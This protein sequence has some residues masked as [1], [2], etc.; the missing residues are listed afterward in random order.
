[1]DKDQTRWLDATDQATLVRRREVEPLELV[2]AAIERIEELDPAIGAV[3]IRWFD[4]ALEQAAQATTDVRPEDAPFPG[5]P[6]LLKDLHLHER[7]Q[8]LTNGNVAL[9]HEQPVSTFDAELVTRMRRTGLVTLGR[10][11]SSE[12]GT[13]PVTE[14]AAY[15]PTRNPWN[16]D[17]TPG[18]S[19]GG[20]AAA[21]AAGMVP[22]AHASDGGGSIRIPA[23]CCGLVGLKPTNGRISLAPDRTET[24]LAVDFFVTRSVRD[25]AQLLD[26]VSGS[27]V[28]DALV[29]APPSRPFA[30]E[31]GAEPG[32]LR[33][34]LLDQHPL[35][36]A[37]HPDCVEAVQT[38]ARRLEDLGH[39][40]EPSWPT[41][42]A[43]R[44]FDE[45][46]FVL[47]AVSR[48][49]GIEQCSTMLGRPLEAAEVEAHDWALGEFGRAVSGVDHANALA[50]AA[51]MRRAILAWW[52]EG[53]D[54]LL[55]PTLAAPPL[56]IGA[57]DPPPNNPLQA[58]VDA[59]DFVGF[60]GAFNVT[61]QPAISIPATWNGDGLPIGVQLVADRSAE[62]LLLRVAS[63]LE[64]AHP[65]SHRTPPR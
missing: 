11:T 4:A 58:L 17:R 54:L 50:S 55:T 8:V 31:V 39:H 18:G 15:G 24:G 49:M 10:S 27:G 1:M 63:Q 28:G 2:E 35:G 51:A 34:G 22:V 36:R 6:T 12:L 65:W 53:F 40:V 7:G 5:V 29:M 21:V 33:I 26:A 20:A 3:A 60:T 38:V 52:A 56:P 46:F 23:S 32:R 16:L 64:S 41:A 43:D 47:W 57:L 9:Q 19:S 37:L 45:M 25:A 62:E 14:T 13:L 59:N 44:S 61:G 48:A 42:L 30:E